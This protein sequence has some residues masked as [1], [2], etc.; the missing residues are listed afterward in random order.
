M[1]GG[2]PAEGLAIEAA[3]AVDLGPCPDC[4]T[5]TR[6]VW[7]HVRR[8]GD[9]FAAY[10]VEWTIGRPD[11][12]AFFDLIVGDWGEGTSS[13]DRWGCSLDYRIIEGKGAFMVIDSSQR[14]LASSNL[15]GNLLARR[16]IIGTERA[17][18]VFALVDAVLLQEP[19]IGEIRSWASEQ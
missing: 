15:V 16:H 2:E 3:G 9:P 6:R 19:R 17:G 14:P 11:H 18:A 12:G 5:D 1:V 4:G 13:A 10:F 7:G 8:G